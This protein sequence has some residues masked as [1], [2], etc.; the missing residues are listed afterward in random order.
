MK[1]RSATGTG[2]G[3]A[4]F[5]MDE[6]LLLLVY[7]YS[8]AQETQASGTQDEEKVEREII[9]ALT[10]LLTQQTTLSPLVQDITGTSVFKLEMDEEMIEY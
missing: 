3:S 10:L 4:D 9:G 6:L 1:S 7:M 5:S 8:L 2:S